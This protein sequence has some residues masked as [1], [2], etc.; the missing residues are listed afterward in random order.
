MEASK[1]PTCYIIKVSRISTNLC[2]IVG[3]TQTNTMAHN[4]RGNAKIERLWQFVAKCLRQMSDKE[5]ENF[6]L[7]CRAMEHA[8]DT[9]PNTQGITPFELEHGMPC[10]P[11]SAIFNYQ[12]AQN[13]HEPSTD[14][15]AAITTST[16]AFSQIAHN[17]QKLQAQ[18]R[19]KLL[20][21]KGTFKSYKI[22]D[23]ISFYIPP[24]EQE[25]KAAGRKPKHLVQFR[26]AATITKSESST[27]SAF[28]IEYQGRSYY[29]SVINLNHYKSQD[30]SN[31][32]Q[33]EIDK[34]V[35][36]ND[37]VAMRDEEDNPHIDKYHI[38]K[39][40]DVN[41]DNIKVWY[42]GTYQRNIKSAKWRPI[43]VINQKYSFEKPRSI[44]RTEM[45]L[46]NVIHKDKIY[47]SKIQLTPKGL[48]IARKSQ[49]QLSR[50]KL[51]HHQLGRTFAK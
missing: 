51:I 4:P 49:L 23:K 1:T 24:S 50:L 47:L 9:T 40:L 6:H 19:A 12:Y 11:I 34:D 8:W 30:T 21:Q 17:Y 3:C 31:L 32:R 45:R 14:E 46:T 18:D 16:K 20:N 39:V 7:Y 36:I 10:R 42:Y 35:I 44:R 27:N 22:G 41:E 43:Y 25:A 48:I 38:A 5:H 28:K 33:P 13:I 29:R 15:I 2:R 26:G 37:F